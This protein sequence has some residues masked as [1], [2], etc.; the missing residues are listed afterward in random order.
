LRSYI[1]GRNIIKGEVVRPKIG[2]T[3]MLGKQKS[4]K[5]RRLAAALLSAALVLQLGRH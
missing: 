5:K 2:E 3:M 1:A 4:A